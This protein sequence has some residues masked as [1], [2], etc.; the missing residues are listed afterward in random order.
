MFLAMILFYSLSLC[1]ELTWDTSFK[2]NPFGLQ[3]SPL[4]LGVGY[5][6][7]QRPIHLTAQIKL[8]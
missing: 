2:L 4:P 8:N 7:G 1:D 5:K 6:L 3:C